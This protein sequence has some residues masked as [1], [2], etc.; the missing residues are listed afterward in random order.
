[1]G[2]VSRNLRSNALPETIAI[3]A[4]HPPISNFGKRGFFQSI[5]NRGSPMS[6]PKHSSQKSKNLGRGRPSIY[7]EE[8]ANQICT[9][10]ALGESVRKICSTDDTPNEETIYRWVLNNEDFSKKYRLAREMQQ[11]RHLDELLEIADDPPP[12]TAMGATDSGAIQHARLRIDTR[13]WAMARLSPKKYG[14][15]LDMSHGVQADNSLASLIRRI[16]GTGLPV[17]KDDPE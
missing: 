7:S 16:S 4:V 6:N 3:E 15:K 1:M 13:K 10:I 5:Q 2:G 12:L 11:E 17:V 8:L 9:R 14:E